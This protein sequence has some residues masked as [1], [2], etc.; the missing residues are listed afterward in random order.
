MRLG[1]AVSKVSERDLKYDATADSRL[2]CVCV[3]A[4]TI[5]DLSISLERK[6]HPIFNSTAWFILILIL[7]QGRN[8]D[9]SSFMQTLRSVG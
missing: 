9:P 7:I 3:Q 5:C 6:H 1:K 8:S 2:P 4:V